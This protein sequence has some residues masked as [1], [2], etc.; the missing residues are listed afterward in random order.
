MI[1]SQWQ[2]LQ[3]FLSLFLQMRKQRFIEVR[4]FDQDPI[5]KTGERHELNHTS[6]CFSLQSPLWKHQ[7]LKTEFSKNF[8]LEKQ[9]YNI[10]L[11]IL[12]GQK[13]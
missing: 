6:H 8:P 13:C 5:T 2:Y 10:R 4:Y 7:P 9:V 12:R 1:T 11:S 3:N